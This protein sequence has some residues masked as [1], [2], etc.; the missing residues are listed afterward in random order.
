METLM[1]ATFV[2][3]LLLVLGAAT[4]NR[5]MYEGSAQLACTLTSLATGST[6]ESATKANPSTTGD[7]DS[8]VAVTFTI[9]SGSPSTGGAAVVNVYAGGS[10]DGTSRWP[11][12]QLSSGA[13]KSTGAGD[14]AIGAL[15]S[16][17]NL[18]LVGRF[19]LQST[20]SSAER[21]FRTEAFSI[22]AAF[23]AAGVA[24]PP[25]F[26]IFVEN[27]SGVALSSSTTTTA[28]YVELNGVYSSSG[29]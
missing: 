18:V 3:T 26:S 28:Q 21:T 13:T 12:V 19:G 17:P 15:G 24:P 5:P 8:Y 25:A 6:R 1:I 2:L 29:N 16:P 22:A 23:A 14:A 7:F 27:Q 4:T 11:I 9:A 10:V 20:T